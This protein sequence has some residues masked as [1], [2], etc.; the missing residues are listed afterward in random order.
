MTGNLVVNGILAAILYA[1]FLWTP[2]TTVAISAAA[3]LMFGYVFI[4]D[5]SDADKLSLLFGSGISAIALVASVAALV[6]R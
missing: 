5:K 6:S 2:W 4:V 3:S 1:S